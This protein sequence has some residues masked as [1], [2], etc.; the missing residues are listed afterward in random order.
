MDK[1]KEGGGREEEGGR[2]GSAIVKK[3]LAVFKK[4]FS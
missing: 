2:V 3:F 1:K 4:G